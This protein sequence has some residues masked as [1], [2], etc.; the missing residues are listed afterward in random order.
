[1]PS[2]WGE[3]RDRDWGLGSDLAPRNRD[4]PRRSTSLNEAGE[5]RWRTRWRPSLR[6]SRLIVWRGGAA[7]HNEAWLLALALNGTAV[8][9]ERVVRLA[10]RYGEDEALKVAE[11]A[12]V[13]RRVV[14][15][16][17]ADGCLIIEARLPAELGAL[18]AKALEA[19]MAP[20]SGSPVEPED[21]TAV[22]HLAGESLVQRRAD[23]FV[24]VASQAKGTSCK[25]S[26]K[27]AT[28]VRAKPTL[29]AGR[30]SRKRPRDASRVTPAWS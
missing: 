28:I 2:P 29:T 19:A 6:T 27:S 15:R 24:A 17:D 22:T 30:P 25:S 21:V 14:M 11:R 18:V 9:V 20:P 1:M 13:Q 10:R 23:A 12:E 3:G 4:R 26:S 16:W 8:H 5:R 7:S